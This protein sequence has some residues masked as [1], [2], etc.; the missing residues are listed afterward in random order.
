M[1]RPPHRV[2]GEVVIRRPVHEV[3][4]FYRDFTNLP[5]VLGD[6][7]AVDHVAGRTYRWTVAGPLGRRIPMW[8]TITE[9]RPDRLLRYRTGGP[10]LLRGQWELSFTADPGGTRVRERLVVPLGALG[11]A[12]LALIGKHP[13]RE[14]AANLRSLKQ[15]LEAPPAQPTEP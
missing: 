6:V 2:T 14:V 10:P 1:R 9:E 11:S 5:R 8:V 15:V 13:D 12:A 4:G 7:V 3:Y